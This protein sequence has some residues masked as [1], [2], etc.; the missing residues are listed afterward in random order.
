MGLPIIQHELVQGHMT[1]SE[2]NDFLAMKKKIEELEQRVAE[3]EAK[4]PKDKKAA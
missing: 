2:R 3:L 1:F 4:K